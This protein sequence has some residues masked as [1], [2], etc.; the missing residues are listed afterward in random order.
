[1]EAPPGE[2]SITDPNKKPPVTDWDE[3]PHEAETRVT[4]LDEYAPIL[5]QE[6]E[7]AM[8]KEMETVRPPEEGDAPPAPAGN[9]GDDADEDAETI[10]PPSSD[11]EPASAAEPDPLDDA[12]EIEVEL[13][14]DD[15]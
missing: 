8:E 12:T 2:T 11:S 9:A 5:E 6:M 13:D 3:D 7:A 14:L 15:F 4:R 10:R 1:M